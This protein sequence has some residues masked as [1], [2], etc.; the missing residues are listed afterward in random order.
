ML[1]FLATTFLPMTLHSEYTVELLLKYGLT[2]CANDEFI[3]AA[4]EQK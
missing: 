2:K 1:F 4:S 3:E